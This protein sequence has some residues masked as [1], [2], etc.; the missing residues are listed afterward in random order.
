VGFTV[1]AGFMEVGGFTAVDV[2]GFAVGGF[3]VVVVLVVGGFTAVVF[4]VVV[5]LTTGLLTA[6]T[7]FFTLG[8]KK[9]NGNE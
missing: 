9:I 4:A 2:K 5:V 3:T 7:V 6:V 1:V 8:T